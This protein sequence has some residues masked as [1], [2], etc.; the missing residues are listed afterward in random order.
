VACY[1][2]HNKDQVRKDSVW[3]SFQTGNLCRNNSVIVALKP[4]CAAAHYSSFDTD[5][6]FN[7]E[8]QQAWNRHTQKAR[9]EQ[10]TNGKCLYPIIPGQYSET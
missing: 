2:Y 5:S 4:L 7:E 10:C 8:P 3:V 6:G 1:Q 9:K